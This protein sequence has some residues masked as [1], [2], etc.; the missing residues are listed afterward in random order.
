RAEGG[1]LGLADLAAYRVRE[2]PVC[3]ADFAGYVVNGR[4]DLSGTVDTLRRIDSGLW[5]EPG[6][7]AVAAADA[8]TTA[9]DGQLGDTTNVSVVDA[10]GNACVVTTTLGIGSGVWPRGTG[11]HLNSMLGEGELLCGPSV[12]GARMSSMMSPLVVRDAADGRVVLAAGAAGASRIRTALVHTLTGVLADGLSTAEAIAAPR[13]HPVESTV[14]AEEGLDGEVCGA[15]ERAGYQ[16]V[17]WDRDVHYFGGVS[18]VGDAGAAGDPR[19]DGAG[20]LAQPRRDGAGQ[21]AQPRR[22]GTGS[23]CGSDAPSRAPR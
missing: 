23:I 20:R 22:D 11:I 19:R 1:A 4:R 15:L 8:L 16:L 14:H 6:K 9:D 10:A 21:L 17:T 3:S 5:L 12:P 2:V 18:A 13:F 7:R